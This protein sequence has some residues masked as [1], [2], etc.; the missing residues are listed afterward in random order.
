MGDQLG[1]RGNSA[2]SKA[3]KRAAL[4]AFDA[5]R[6]SSP[7]RATKYPLPFE[8]LPQEAVCGL[9]IYIDYAQFLVNEARMAEGNRNAGKHPYSFTVSHSL[10]LI[11]CVSFTVSRLLCLVY[12]VSFTVSHSLGLIRCASFPVSHSLCL[13][14]RTGGHYGCGSV[15]DY[16]GCLINMASDRWKHC[17]TDTAKL[18][19]T[20]LD[21][22]A[23]TEVPALCP[24][25]VLPHFVLSGGQAIP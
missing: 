18:C 25:G 10:C 13:N 2:A 24:H 19:F 8:A 5:M 1:V 17:G 6:E 21:A 23:G 16:L 7:D 3:T 4:Q 9:V 12:C 15:L 11:H 14:H 22:N 20:C